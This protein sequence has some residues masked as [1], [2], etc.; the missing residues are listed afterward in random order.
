MGTKTWVVDEMLAVCGP[1]SS[2]A[3]M[4]IPNA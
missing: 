3:Q 4:I 1:T 2:F